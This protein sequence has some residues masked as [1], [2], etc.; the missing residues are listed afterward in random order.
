MSNK[1][2][3]IDIYYFF[4]D[5]MNIKNFDPD[6]IKKDEKSY[7]NIL[8][9]LI[10]HV[11]IK[12]LKY[13]KVNSVNPLYLISNKANRYLKD[14]NKNKYL[15]LVSTNESKEIKNTKNCGVQSEI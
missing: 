4:N 14:F 6:K 7:K 8:I 13:V 5:I 10:G 11:T 15:M 1:F 12:D 3:N 9:Y 2:K